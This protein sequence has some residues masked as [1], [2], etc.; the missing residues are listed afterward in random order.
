MPVTPGRPT[1]NHFFTALYPAALVLRTRLR[2]ALSV[3]PC[4][5]LV[6]FSPPLLECSGCSD[7]LRRLAEGHC[8]ISCSLLPRRSLSDS[9]RPVS[10]ASGGLAVAS[11]QGIALLTLLVSVR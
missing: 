6:A 3:S 4:S 10:R 2:L 9:P 7:G 5:T 8:M 1:K 11:H